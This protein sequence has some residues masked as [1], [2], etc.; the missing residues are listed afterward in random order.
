[1]RPPGGGFS[2]LFET[3]EHIKRALSSPGRVLAPRAIVQ[4][5][6]AIGRTFRAGRQEDAHEFARHLMEGMQRDASG[7]RPQPAGVADTSFVG[8]ARARHPPRR[9]PTDPCDVFMPPPLEISAGNG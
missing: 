5:L 7:R 1:M 4:N 9:T 3:A 2:A 8:Q 6:R